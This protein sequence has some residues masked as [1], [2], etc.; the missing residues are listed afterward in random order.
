MQAASRYPSQGDP[1][2][3]TVYT[4]NAVL[5]NAAAYIHI[6]Y[7]YMYI[8]I[9]TEHSVDVIPRETGKPDTCVTAALMPG[10]ERDPSI[11]AHR[12]THIHMYVHMYIHTA[13]VYIAFV[14]N[15]LPA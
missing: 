2:T 13:S 4:V 7:I 1:L 3:A 15:I 9:C 11:I 14:A 5:C 12:H 8:C 10:K 6:L